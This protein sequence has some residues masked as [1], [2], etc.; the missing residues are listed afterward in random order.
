MSTSADAVNA[1]ATVASDRL[2]LTV[3]RTNGEWAIY[4]RTIGGRWSGPA[5]RLC[6]IEIEPVNDELRSGFGTRHTEIVVDR[7]EDVRVDGG[8]IRLE[9]VPYHRSE[10][11]LTKMTIEFSLA[12]ESDDVVLGYE[13]TREDPGWTVH[14]VK[15]VDDALPIT[16][17]GAHAILPAFQGEVV[18]VGS[19]FSYLPRDRNVST[20]TSN[21]VGTYSGAIEWNM[22]MFA[23]V[24][25]SSTA[26]V[27]WDSPNVEAGVR[28]DD[29]ADGKWQI[30]ASVSLYREADSIRLHFME[31]AGYVR[32][33]KYYREIT[34]QR[35]LFDTLAD[36]IARRPEL[37]K[38]VGA[39][40][41][42][43]APKWGRSES[44][45]WAT[46]VDV[47]ETRIDYTFDEVAQVTEHFVNDL[48]IDKG[49]TLVKAWS[50]GGY[51]MDYPDILPA[52]EECGGNEG[53]A[54]ASERVRSLG[55]LLGVHDNSLLMFRDA[56]STDVSDAMIRTDGTP[57]GDSITRWRTY[58]CC[59][60]RMM[61]HATRNYPQLKELFD[62]NLLYSDM[63]AAVPLYECFSD[64]H[65]MTRMETIEAY[66]E[67]VEYGK[68]H[69]GV[70][71]S[72]IADEW[73]VPI[74][75]AMGITTVHSH[76][77]AYP[78]PLFE[79]VYRECVNLE[80]WPWGSMSVPDVIDTISR[81]RMVYFTFPN[82]DYLQNGFDSAPTA[83]PWSS[84]WR[85]FHSD[86]NPFMRADQGWAEEF[87]R[88]DQLIKNVH[89]V[90]SPLNE[91]TAYSEMTDHVYLTEDRLVERVSFSDGTSIVTNR[92]PEDYGHEGT[93][94]PNFGFLASGPYYE[95]F[96]ARRHGGVEYPG[97]ALFTARSLDGRPL[98][99]SSEVRVYHGFGEP[100]IAIGGRTFEVARE[101]VVDVRGS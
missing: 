40:R 62:L 24:G 96:Y 68:D 65:P 95:A 71:T 90:Q 85:N 41:F 30:R 83:D 1:V 101:A 2:K 80:S 63:L 52:A 74:F 50:H 82:R 61:K 70:V 6:S 25:G 44:G 46:F 60:A 32:V 11:G 36:K 76:D 49:V 77:Y 72:E 20:R 92:G 31:D 33:A 16:K 75:D 55:W 5:G 38:N 18:P 4:H 59:P 15:I 100:Q 26:V 29:Q 89:E 73:A 27:H 56:P 69:F 22:A 28:G 9:Y 13:V 43:V 58:Q 94:M 64:D 91:L 53:L 8:V 3:D 48:G 21:V 14:S 23:L 67:L 87:D 93:L 19:H 98:P 42:T 39:L 35:W 84:W 12:V 17:D 86:D 81:G 10:V 47:G 57:V 88:Y 34:R 99:E 79:L 45:G 37:E 54:Q 78:V 66:R 7:F 97:G 51:D